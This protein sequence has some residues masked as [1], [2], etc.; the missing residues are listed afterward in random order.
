MASQKRESAKSHHSTFLTRDASISFQILRPPRPR[1]ARGA[2]CDAADTR[3]FFTGDSRGAEPAL[4]KG[5]PIGN[6]FTGEDGWSMYHG[7]NVPGFPQHPHRGFETVTLAR[8]GYATPW[9]RRARFGHGDVQ[10][11]TAGRGVIRDTQTTL[12]PRHDNC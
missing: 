3:H 12:Q 10:W 7:Q 5:R 4:L 8:Q 9:A 11:M 6:D 2:K 1:A